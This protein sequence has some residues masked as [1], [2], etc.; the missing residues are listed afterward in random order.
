MTF[1][2][3]IIAVS[4]DK[5]TTMIAYP[6]KTKGYVRVKSYG[7]VMYINQKNRLIH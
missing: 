2:I 4:S 7:N 1:Y 5:T 3:G 6:D